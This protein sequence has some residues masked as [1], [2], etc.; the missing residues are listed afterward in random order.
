MSMIGNYIRLPGVDL[1]HFIADPEAIMDYLYP[2]DDAK[3]PNSDHLDIDK[4]WQ[5][6]HFLLTGSAWDGDA[7]LK[8]IVLGGTEIGDVDVGYGPARY[9]IPA[10]VSEAALALSSIAGDELWGRF[11]LKALQDNEIY[12]S[13]WEGSDMEREYVIDHFQRLKAF[14]EEAHIDNQAVIL[15][16]N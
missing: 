11:D 8:N 15:Y 12:P 5:I 1:A 13:G 16:I 9:L 2:E 14:L 3:F 10:E 6:I 7:P 4:A